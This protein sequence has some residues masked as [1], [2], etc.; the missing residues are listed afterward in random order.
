MAR[1]KRA[2]HRTQGSVAV[3]ILYVEPSEFEQAAIERLWA[4][5]LSDPK[6]DDKGA[7]GPALD[8]AV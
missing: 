5:L 6:D 1:G 8:E 4:A 2:N 3:R 7:A